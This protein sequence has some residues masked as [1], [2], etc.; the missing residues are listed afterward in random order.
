MESALSVKSISADELFINRLPPASR[1]A[2]LQFI[3]LSLLEQSGWYLG[4]GTALAL[5][6]GHRQ[7]VDL[8][9][10]TPQPNFS[11]LALE[12]QLLKTADW[13]TNFSESST[14]Y[15]EFMGAKVSFIAYPFFIPSPQRTVC[16][17]IRLLIPADIAVMKVIA[18]SQ[19]GKKRDFI[20]LF[21]YCHN[22]EELVAVIRR[23][24]QHYPGQAHN[25]SHFLKSLTYFVDAEHDP[26]PKLFFKANW[27]TVKKFFQA[28]APLVIKEFF[29]N[30]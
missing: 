17:T 1:R 10:F 25:L 28:E 20:D 16:G 6:V 30:A 15:G 23:V 3:K 26:M 9:F 29:Q 2:F 13:K 8:D 11:E 22:Q 7:S 18:T 19:R 12:R 21:W 4:G 24:P 5:Q 27:L 14:I